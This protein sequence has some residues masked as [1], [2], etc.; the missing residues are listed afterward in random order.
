M[1]IKLF[2]LAALL[3][4]LNCV[5]RA[6]TASPAPAEVATKFLRHLE[7]SEVDEAMKLWAPSATNERLKE[8]VRKMSVKIVAFGGIEKIKTP[9]VEKRPKNL[10]SHEVVVIVVYGNKNLAFGSISF[11]EQDGQY[12]ISNLRSEQGWGG[13]TSL[14]DETSASTITDQ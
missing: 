10:E 3:A 12:K 13:T 6:D 14:F 9:P 11:I 7:N 5:A 8:R 1:K 2:L 4:L